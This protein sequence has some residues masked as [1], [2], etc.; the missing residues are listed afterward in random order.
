M[1]FIKKIVAAALSLSMLLSLTACSD[2]TWAVDYS[3]KQLS[4]GMYILYEMSAYSAASQ[5]VEDKEADMFKQQI[6]GVDVTEWI[7]NE[8]LKSC[9]QYMAIENKFEE[10]GLSLSEQ[11]IAI[12]NNIV[13]NQWPSFQTTYE[14]NGVSMDN[15][16]AVMENSRKSLAIFSAYYDEGGIEAVDIESIRTDFF[17][18][19]IKIASASATLAMSFDEDD[20]ETAADNQRVLDMFEQY[21]KDYNAGKITLGEAQDDYNHDLF[22]TVHD[23]EDIGDIIATD[24]SLTECMR[25]DEE[26]TGFSAEWIEKIKNEFVPDGDADLVSDEAAVFL[27]KRFSLTEE[28]Y[29]EHK[30]T[31]LAEMKGDEFTA[32][33]E[34]WAEALEKNVN[35]ASV[36]RYAPKKIKFN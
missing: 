10:L 18:N 27:I 26:N 29:E 7:R 24:E 31:V 17:D 5:A 32:M 23:D 4:A 28:D 21:K 20:T 8:T 12:V 34:Q 36:N 3:G 16:R 6:D 2:T 30:E 25:A 13:A 19:Y 14:K 9:D 35:Q 11:D 1:N 33:V 22:D 15:Y